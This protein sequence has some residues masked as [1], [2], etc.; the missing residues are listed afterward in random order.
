MTGEDVEMC[1]G[2][3]CITAML[4]RYLH[5]VRRVHTLFGVSQQEHVISREIQNWVP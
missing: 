4:F 3:K 1:T 5:V 2:Y